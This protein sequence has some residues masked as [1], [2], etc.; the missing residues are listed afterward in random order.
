[1]KP[2][3]INIDESVAAGLTQF[4]VLALL[5][6]I[7]FWDILSFFSTALSQ[8]RFYSLGHILILDTKPAIIYVN[9]STKY[10]YIYIKTPV[11]WLNLL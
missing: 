3:I 8:F 1:M 6:S 4:T 5:N 7:S 9:N 11:L 10:M 2:S